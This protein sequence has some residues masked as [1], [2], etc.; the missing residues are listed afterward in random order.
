MKVLKNGIHED[1]L[2]PTILWRHS[3][4]F[5]NFRIF[6]A[7]YRK[8]YTWLLKNL[9]TELNFKIRFCSKVINNQSNN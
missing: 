3:I 6:G 9:K 5:F 7:R 4:Y 1:P 2:L 8:D